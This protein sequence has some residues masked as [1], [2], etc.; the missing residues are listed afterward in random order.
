MPAVWRDAQVIRMLS[1]PL[2]LVWGTPTVPG[3]RWHL[4]LVNLKAMP[5]RD[6][7][8]RRTAPAPAELDARRKHVTHL[9]LRGFFLWCLGLAVAGYLSAAVLVLQRLE[10]RYPKIELSYLDVALPT[11]W[12]ELNSKRGHALIAQGREWMREKKV[13]EGFSL[14][15]QGLARS[16]EEFSARLDIAR[17]YAWMRLLPQAIKLLRDGFV[18][19][20]PGKAYLET[21]FGLLSVTDQ[22]EVALAVVQSA[23][24]LYDAQ[25]ASARTPSEQRFLDESL[26]SALRD[27]GRNEEAAR[28]V[29]AAFPADDLFA[30]KF[31][32]QLHLDA[33]PRESARLAESW[34]AL[35]PANPEP[36]CVLIV[37][38]R[39]AGDLPAMDAALDRLS[40]LDPARPDALLYRVVQNHLAGR[41]EE[42][43]AAMER[44]FFRHGS[45][46]AFYPVVCTSFLGTGYVEGFDRVE[47]E[48]R[49][50]GL[51][52]HPVLWARVKLAAERSDWPTLITQTELLRAAPGP[53][54]KRD[55]L[56]YLD[57][58]A[59]LARACLDGGSGTQ[60][61]L[62]EVV[63]DNPGT[64]LLYK[65]AITAL[66][67]ADRPQTARQIL[68]LAEGPFPD[69][70]TLREL[71]PRLENALAAAAAA[72]PAPA[73]ASAR[74]ATW[75]DF[76][77]EFETQAASAPASAL[78]LVA[79]LRR[80]QPVWLED[81]RAELETLELP[82][83][84]RG[85][86]P[87]LLQVLVRAMLARDNLAPKTLLPL[88]RS[89]H[90]TFPANARLILKETLRVHP[91]D[92]DALA[93]QRVWEP[94]P[95]A[96][97]P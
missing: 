11:R 4:A 85:D 46:P 94:A 88:A 38:L 35:Q 14:L 75:A 87:L 86:D 49:E 23:R 61:S 24:G 74:F 5:K 8:H 69:A 59:K 37:A 30:L 48:L 3:G 34:A 33:R 41:P 63:G 81:H 71:R 9:S 52:L 21:L 13:A 96:P 25:P 10:S 45:S 56:A 93:L 91:E 95:T 19:G 29:A 42:A 60:R 67:N 55:E 73:P 57:T 78:A 1:Q 28:H 12:S 70:R 66:L 76:V 64:L 36:L 43:R 97:S 31:L 92:E 51:S 32:A 62:V 20:Y 50:R 7:K 22:N 18:H 68:V 26:A 80:A 47:N 82:P 15:R 54:L 65:T 17:V 40:R 72:E 89:I 6:R 39:Q 77:T 84:A 2:R 58:M 44:L 53:E 90:P 16:P 83:R 79:E 27:A